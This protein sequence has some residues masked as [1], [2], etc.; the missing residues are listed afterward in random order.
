MLY[1]PFHYFRV[2]TTRTSCDLIERRYLSAIQPVA[3][4]LFSDF[5]DQ[6]IS[7]TKVSAI[8]R[9]D[10][11]IATTKALHAATCSVGTAVAASV[12]F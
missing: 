1:N 11:T 2:K 9:L 12:F 7:S 4:L 3:Q 5:V 10:A 8:G 6:M